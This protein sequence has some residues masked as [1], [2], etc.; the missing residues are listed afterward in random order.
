MKLEAKFNSLIRR[1]IEKAVNEI[2]LNSFLC[3]GPAERLAIH[4]TATVQNALFNTVSGN[5]NI[6]ERVFFGHNVN[7]LTGSHDYNRCDEERW[8]PAPSLNDICILR[9]AWIASNAVIIGP[10]V[11]GE[12]A[13]VA[14]GSIVI[15]D[16]PPNSMVAG[17]PATLKRMIGRT[18]D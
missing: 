2:R 7:I 6:G 5:I 11:I 1:I 15:N 9:G 16:V 8:K 13:V 17:N 4:P 12:N 18:I 3:F 14:A 10:C